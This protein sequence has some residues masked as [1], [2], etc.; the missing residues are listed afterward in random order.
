MFSL[1]CAF[2]DDQGRKQQP[3]VKELPQW[4]RDNFCNLYIRRIIKSVC[5]GNTPWNNPSLQSL[6]QEF[7]YA[8]PTHQIQL[9]STDAAV[10]P[11]SIDRIHH[12]HPLTPSSQTTRDLGVL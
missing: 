10:V 3:G 6:Q 5:L 11:V 1:P 8:Y 7:D 9:Q 12:V 2:I 4:L